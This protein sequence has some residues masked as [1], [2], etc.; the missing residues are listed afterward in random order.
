[1]ATAKEVYRA[2][3]FTGLFRGI[4]AVAIGA[5]P[6][7]AIYFASYEFF[8]R[9]TGGS[10]HNHGQFYQTLAQGLSG[11]FSNLLAEA[12]HTPMDTIK[13][14]RQLGLKAYSGTFNCIAT[15]VRVEGFRALYASYTTTLTMGIPFNF[16][17]FPTYE[18]LRK[19]FNSDPTSYDPVAHV[20]AG[21][22]AGAVAAAFTNPFDVSKTRL[23]TQ[24]DV[25]KT[26]KGMADAL[27]RIWKEEGIKGYT[28]GIVPR[29]LFYTT[30]AGIGWGTY[31]YFKHLLG[32][33]K[34]LSEVNSEG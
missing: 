33:D 3:G 29:V 19:L 20:C 21:G 34:Y 17:Y 6:A 18:L 22:G 10:S 5:G 26:Y 23:Q 7:H 9:Q 14:K 12:V 8:K 1:V 16:C 28:R 15:V 27:I 32:A 24:G 13:Q 25:G 31:E 4:S 11:V 30:S 2:R